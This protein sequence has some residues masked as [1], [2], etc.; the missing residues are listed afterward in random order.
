MCVRHLEH[1]R[2]KE[3]GLCFALQL[4]YDIGNYFAKG[5]WLMIAYLVSFLLKTQM[6]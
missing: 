1:E 4:I 6:K 2:L 3:K 5:T